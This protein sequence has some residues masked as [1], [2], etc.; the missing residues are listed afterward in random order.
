MQISR[1]EI[2]AVIK[3]MVSLGW[4]EPSYF[5]SIDKVCELCGH[6]GMSEDERVAT[7]NEVAA[8]LEAYENAKKENA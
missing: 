7:R 2:D 5:H 8:M 3:E 6:G 4:M 1:D